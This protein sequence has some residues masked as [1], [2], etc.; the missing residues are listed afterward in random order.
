[1]VRTDYTVQCNMRQEAPVDFRARHNGDA[2]TEKSRSAAQLREA[3]GASVD[4]LFA[5]FHSTTHG[6]TTT[7]AEERLKVDGPNLVAHER[8]PSWYSQLW[9]GFANAFSAL[10]AVLS[11]VSWF[12]GDRESALI[13]GAMVLL[14]GLLRFFQERRASLAA[15][16][17][18]EMVRVTCTVIRQEADGTAGEREIP[19]RELVSGDLVKLSAGDMVPADL[20]L[21]TAK[22][23]FVAQSA[24]TGEAIPAEKSAASAPSPARNP[25]ELG[26]IAFLGTDV[27]SGTAVGLIVNTGQ[28][29]YFGSIAES[30]AGP[31]ALT[32]FE[33][34]IRGVSGLL[35]RFMAVM[36]VLVFFINGL[37]KHDWR[38]AFFFALAVAVGLTPEMLPMILS[39]TLAIGAVAMSKKKVIVKRLNSIQNFGAMDVLC[40][41]KTGTLT[42]DRVV[43]ELYC[44][45][46][47][48]E[49]EGVLRLAYLNSFFQTGLKN[50]LDKALIAHGT[51]QTG[52]V[53]KVDEIPFDFS[54]RIMSVVVDVDGQRKLIAKGAPEAIF[55][56]CSRVE[57]NGEVQELD[58]LLLP[59]L[60]EE[61]DHLQA[62]GFRVLAIAYKDLP[63]D[64]AVYSSKDECEL[65]L[66]GYV[67]F[68]DPPK[69]S[70]R[71]AIAALDTHGVHVKVLTGDNDIVARKICGDVGLTVERVVL[72]QDIETASDE[73]LSAIVEHAVLFA[74]LAP[75]HKERVVRA[76]QHNGHVVGFM[77][78][79]INDAPALR[80][81]DVGISVDNAVDIAK[82]S[83][84]VIL[85]EKDLLVLEAG[86]L[87]GRRVFGNITKYIKMGT[88]SNFG[89][90]FSVV[91]ASAFLPF[92]P[93]LPIQLLTQNL[94]YDFSQ[95]AIPFDRVDEEY[96]L[97]PRRWRV[98]DIGRFMLFFGPVS[99]VFDY[100]TFGLLYFVLKANTVEH[101]SLFQSGW[102]VEGLLSQ[103]LIVH[104]IRTRKLP[105]IQSR[106]ALSL[107]LSTLAVMAVGAL[108]PFTAFGHSLGMVGL[109]MRFFGWLA[110]VL[111]AYMV[112][113]Q[114]V[115][116]WFI[117]RYGYN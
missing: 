114:L 8:P 65:I 58:P 117:R 94:L 13:I 63:K 25:L 45:V 76:L 102:F 79:G 2:A 15:Q 5:A 116:S 22:D 87:E 28:A 113:A 32:S 75:A 67:A 97:R 53:A 48:K 24:L 37:T 115:K 30:L 91:G 43:L 3:A 40:T 1:M 7:A 112:L 85:L 61:L 110:L 107:A 36:T 81:A 88:S 47:R 17:L 72:G 70:S 93:M 100:V 66:R 4:E 89:N 10:L 111:L 99:S 78:D 18:Q 39:G 57:V 96:L 21:V 83:A 69:G 56:R 101:Q 33:K 105:F 74:R 38:Q 108:L 90:M 103:T 9:H 109:P 52:D 77:G 60:G 64:R 98:D 44:D 68:L 46:V 29:T 20:R 34:G 84:D 50:L 82:E 27:T 42:E 6:L 31:R 59:D 11:L 55:R 80:S 49:D 16:K 23:L 104:M 26:N 73:D 14:S 62:Q 41:D 51:V 54:R 35:L 12:T 92:L 19:I 106:P 86:V 71:R 95:L